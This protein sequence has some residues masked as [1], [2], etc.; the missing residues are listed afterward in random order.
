M[1][2]GLVGQSMFT[3][4]VNTSGFLDEHMIPTN[5]MNFGILVDTNNNGFS[6]G[7]YSKFDFTI[8]NQYLKTSL[9]TTD[10]LFLSPQN[11]FKTTFSSFLGDGTIGINNY[12]L[13]TGTTGNNFSLIWN[14]P[15]SNFYG[16]LENNAFNVVGIGEVTPFPYVNWETDYM[17]HQFVIPE[18]RFLSFIVSLTIFVVII[19]KKRH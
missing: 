12:S 18:P 2:S 13:I 10:D 3:V 5:G 7:E 16:I 9:S 8:D 15:S 11:N 6:W 19:N 1:C 17:Q 14:E 4:V